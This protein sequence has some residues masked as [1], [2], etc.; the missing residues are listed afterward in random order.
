M[1]GD[2]SHPILSLVGRAWPPLNWGSRG[3]QVLS[4]KAR[5]PLG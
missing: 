5:E 2:V 3:M 1:T 4:W